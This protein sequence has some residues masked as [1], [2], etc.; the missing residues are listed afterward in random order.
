MEIGK[1]SETS[2]GFLLQ[3]DMAKP[4]LAESSK[5]Q[6]SSV[7]S[8]LAQTASPT[9]ELRLLNKGTIPEL[10]VWVSEIRELYHGKHIARSNHLVLQLGE[11]PLGYNKWI[12]AEG[13]GE[14]SPVG[15]ISFCPKG[16]VWEILVP[17]NNRF[18]IIFFED[19][20]IIRNA[21]G[22]HGA[23]NIEDQLLLQ[24]LRE[25]YSEICRPGFAH[26][27]TV[28]ALGLALRTRIA[29]L[30]DFLPTHN[31]ATTSLS[32]E[33]LS[34]IKDM[35]KNYKGQI[36][37][38]ADISI[39]FGM[40]ES[41][42]LRHMKAATGKSVSEYISDVRFEESQKLLS[43]T[44]LSLKEIAFAAGFSSASS[45]SSAFKRQTGFTP[46]TYR[47]MSVA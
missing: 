28:Q 35:I 23:F 2:D 16:D 24:L 46:A 20:E 25:L 32:V 4:S 15:Q 7:P 45:F 39:R 37:K 18:M 6:A 13:N 31:S 41:T 8:Q 47:R 30:Q 5:R 42:L 21:A 19:D 12:D 36:P 1:V 14:F 26:E 40:S 34:E 29:R 22:C 33:Q 38:V 3:S 43:E 17:A 9:T 27:A 44:D 10:E 11:G